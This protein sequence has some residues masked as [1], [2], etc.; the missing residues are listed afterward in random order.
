MARRILPVVCSS[1]LQKDTHSHSHLIEK[2]IDQPPRTNLDR[3]T[4]IRCRRRSGLELN[5]R[6]GK[7]QSQLKSHSAPGLHC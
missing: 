6:S 2:A 5:E 1:V 3:L 4:I 7:G